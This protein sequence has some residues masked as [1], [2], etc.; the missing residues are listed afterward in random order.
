MPA[1]NEYVFAYRILITNEG[2]SPAQL[3]HRQWLITDAL[4]RTEE[5]RGPGVVG[6]QP[7]LS[8]GESFEYESFCPLPT[9]FGQMRGIY[10]MIRD[11]G[12]IFDAEIP[13]F[14]LVQT[15]A[16]VGPSRTP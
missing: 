10:R 2:P 1:H 15:E 14:S 13:T 12:T 11:D 5:V 8:P 9:P 3:I 7:R 4:G 6:K 16:N